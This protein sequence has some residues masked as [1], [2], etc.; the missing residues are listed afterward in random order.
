MNSG[1]AVLESKVIN[2]MELI[3]YNK[4]EETSLY[5]SSLEVGQFYNALDKATAH[6]TRLASKGHLSCQD[7]PNHCK[8]HNH[9]PYHEAVSR[10]LHH[11]EC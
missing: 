4:F 11:R 10:L 6:L 7:Y 1:N 5:Q 2:K 9:R 8:E 3:K